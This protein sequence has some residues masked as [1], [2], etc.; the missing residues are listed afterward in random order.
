[1][2]LAI[3]DLEGVPDIA[4]IDG[5]HQATLDIP[6]RTIIKGD[7]L[8]MSIAAASIVAKVVR[9]EMML[10]FDRKYPQYGFARHKGYATGDHL[11]ALKEFGVCPIHRRS[12]APVRDCLNPLLL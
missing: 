4:L 7:Q 12:F 6:Q 2:K 3:E 9:D 10:E 1:M 5:R 11:A 8:S